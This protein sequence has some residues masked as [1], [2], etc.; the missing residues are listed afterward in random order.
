MNWL[1]M[2]AAASALPPSRRFPLEPRGGMLVPVEVGPKSL[3]SPLG[4]FLVAQSRRDAGPSGDGTKGIGAPFGD[5]SPGCI[6]GVPHESV[7]FFLYCG[8]S[9]HFLH[10]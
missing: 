5:I 8:L 3:L 10:K 6:F 7:E 2:D 1:L 9:V 4:R